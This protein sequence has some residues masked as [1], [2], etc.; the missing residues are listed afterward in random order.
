VSVARAL[1][2]LIAGLG[3]FL[4]VMGIAFLQER[5]YERRCSDFFALGVDTPSQP[6]LNEDM[7]ETPVP[8]TITITSAAFGQFQAEATREGGF[9]ASRLCRDAAEVARFVQ[10]WGR[11]VF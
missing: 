4:V 7:S 6:W 3:V 2:P 11:P 5:R 1:A 9:V 8:V 10:D